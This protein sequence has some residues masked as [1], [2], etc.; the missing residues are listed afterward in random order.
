MGFMG[1]RVYESC[2]V[3][4]VWRVRGLEC[5]FKRAVGLVLAQIAPEIPK[6]LLPNPKP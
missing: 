5:S 1:I 2:R 3:D 4:G 6:S